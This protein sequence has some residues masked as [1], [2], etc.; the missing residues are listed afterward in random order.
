MLEADLVKNTQKESKRQPDSRRI[1]SWEV[2]KNDY[3]RRFSQNFKGLG[4]Y[5]VLNEIFRNLN[6]G[7]IITTKLLH[8]Y[9]GKS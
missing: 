8:W 7:C 1:L 5:H 6:A 2:F 9:T 4:E 3:W